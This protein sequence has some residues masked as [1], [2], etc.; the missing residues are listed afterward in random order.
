MAMTMNKKYENLHATVFKPH[1]AGKKLLE[2]YRVQEWFNYVCLRAGLAHST[3]QELLSWLISQACMGRQLRN[4]NWE[5]YEH[6]MESPSRTILEMVERYLPQTRKIY[7]QGPF[8]L[9]LWAVL[10]GDLSACQMYVNNILRQFRSQAVSSF[11]E[12]VRSMIGIIATVYPQQNWSEQ[13]WYSIAQVEMYGPRSD[14]NAQVQWDGCSYLQ[15]W[16]GVYP[17]LFR[18]LILALIALWQIALARTER[19]EMEIRRLIAGMCQGCIAREFN[20]PTLQSYV[21]GL[22]D[23]G[24]RDVHRAVIE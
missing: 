7:D 9:P 18:E 21:L 14:I 23:E 3:A 5:L 4:V 20:S 6:G 1:S 17:N 19:S 16:G 10:R 15:E 2:R 24:M 11:S 13:M 8:D 12:K 22:L